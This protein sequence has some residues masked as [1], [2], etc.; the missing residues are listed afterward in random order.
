M[1]NKY[2]GYTVCF[3][4]T[5][6]YILFMVC[7]K[8]FKQN[9][10]YKEITKCECGKYDV[11][12]INNEKITHVHPSDIDFENK[13]IK[14]K[15]SELLFLLKSLVTGLF[16]YFVLMFFSAHFCWSNRGL[17]C[18]LNRILTTEPSEECKLLFN[19]FFFPD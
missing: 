1:I 11:K 17:D 16:I 9:I 18:F 13:I 3:L 8:P 12:T 15:P 2:F 14:R 10:K 6:L 4:I 19:K 5:I 7:V